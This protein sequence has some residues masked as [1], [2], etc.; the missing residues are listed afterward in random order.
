MAEKEKEPDPLEPIKSASP[1]IRRII[2]KVL[3][4]EKEHLYEDRPR[5]K[6]NIVA[7]I[8]QEIRDDS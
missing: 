1:P 7:A 5:L 3:Q 6:D 2:K 8:K 4:L